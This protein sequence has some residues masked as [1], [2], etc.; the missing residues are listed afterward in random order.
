[1]EINLLSPALRVEFPFAASAFAGGVARERLRPASLRH[2]ARNRW[3]W[4]RVQHRFH[5]QDCWLERRAA[6]A[7][8]A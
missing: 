1:V 7:R 5:H 2:R 6:H 8:R 3:R 4:P